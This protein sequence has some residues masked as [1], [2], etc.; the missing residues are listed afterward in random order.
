[1]KVSNVV[2]ITNNKQRKQTEYNKP[3]DRSFKQC[4]NKEIERIKN[5]QKYI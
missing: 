2:S 4:L 3:R 1:M 5:E